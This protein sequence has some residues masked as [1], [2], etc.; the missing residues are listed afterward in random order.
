MAEAE[1]EEVLE[2]VAE[3]AKAV[4]AEERKLHWKRRSTPSAT[5]SQRRRKRL[6]R[7]GKSFRR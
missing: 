4:V 5:R 2:E 3:E 1:V 7:L 6:R